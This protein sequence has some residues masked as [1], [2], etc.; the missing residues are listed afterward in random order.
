MKVDPKFTKKIQDWLNKEP[1]EKE[2]ALTGAQLLQQINPR[3]AMYRRF[4]NLSIQRPSQILPKIVYELKTHLK[5]RLDGL[6]L[7]EVN[8]LDREVVPAAA[9]IIA[10]G[11]PAADEDVLLL[12]EKG[13]TVEPAQVI[14]SPE[15]GETNVVKQLGRRA[16]HEQLPDDIKALWDN[17]GTLYK[18]IKSTFEELKSMED[19]PSCQRYDK[20]QLLASMDQKYFRQMKEYDDF[21]IGS[22]EEEKKEDAEQKKEVKITVPSA[23]SYISKYQAKLADLYKAAHVDGASVKDINA[24]QDL[25]IKVQARVNVLIVANEVTDK[26]KESLSV[27]GVVFDTPV[28]DES[29]AASDNAETAG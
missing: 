3:N 1:K 22:E 16:D 26:M 19:L 10:K 17:N 25:V 14:L 13:Q 11:K 23:R 8:R 2:D 28:P 20:L 27:I 29:K 7:E 15:D 5:Y 24:Y 12:D 21:V 18:D 6:T 9:E 4:I